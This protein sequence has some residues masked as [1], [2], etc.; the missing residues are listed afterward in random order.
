MGMAIWVNADEMIDRLKWDFDDEYAESIVEDV[1]SFHSDMVEVVRCK[2]CKHFWES[3]S[4]THSCK[5]HKGLV[6]TKYDAYCSYGE[7]GTDD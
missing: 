4:G 6:G 5:L 7:R 2:D 3:F 1:A